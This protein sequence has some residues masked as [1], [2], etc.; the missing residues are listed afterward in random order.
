M[1]KETFEI[2]SQEVQELLGHVPRWVV[3]WGTIVILIILVLLFILSKTLRYPDIIHSQIQLTTNIPP[4]E[5][6]A[7]IDGSI[8]S[9]LVTDKQA[10][11][12]SQTIAVIQSATDYNDICWL[13]S[14][15][16]DS[17]AIEKYINKELFDKK[18]ALGEIQPSYAAFINTLEEYKNFVD[19]DYYTR[20]LNSL[21]EELAKYKHYLANSK[22]QQAL[23]NKEYLIVEQ[24]FKRDSGLAAKGVLSSIELEK[25]EQAR[26]NKLLDLKQAVSNQNQINI[27]ITNLEQE[28]LD[29]Q[30]QLEKENMN[31]FSTLKARWN[32]LNGAIAQWKE[33]YI[34]A[35]PFD[36]TVSM[37]KIWS[38]NQYVKEGEIVVTVLPK[39]TEK[40]VGR[41]SVQPSGAGKIMKNN[42]VIIQFDN[43]PYLEY[44]VVTGKI[45]SVSLSPENGIYYAKVAIDSTNLITNYNN[46]LIFSQNMQGSAEII[47]ESRTL[48]DRIFAPVKSAIEIQSMYKN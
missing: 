9:I 25:S 36:G 28:K 34:I 21:Q 30:L 24:Q 20:K 32:E 13:S 2:R 43:Y 3:R 22:E 33:K 1:E 16:A 8:K 5:I 14:F 41:V 31:L 12:K 48:F 35:S 42:K 47:T 44:G 23:I 26:L 6:K 29:L 17:F 46:K 4:A 7:N 40:I 11:E 38:E 45:E 19:V 15:L 37:N 39:E 10:V 27:Q 18:L